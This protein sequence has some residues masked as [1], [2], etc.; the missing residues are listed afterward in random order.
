MERVLV[1]LFAF[2]VVILAISGCTVRCEVQ[3]IF[4]DTIQQLLLGKDDEVPIMS[5]KGMKK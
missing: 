4:A 5:K 3:P 1:R 2:I